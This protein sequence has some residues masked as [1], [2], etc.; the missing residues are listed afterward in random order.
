MRQANS[1]LA[2]L[3]RANQLS[4]EQLC[5]LAQDN[6]HGLSFSALVQ[7]ERGER[8]PRLELAIWLAR[9]FDLTV[10]ELFR[11]GKRGRQAENNRGADRASRA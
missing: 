10:E 6:G 11:N 2:K 3:R 4:R 1:K 7:Y 9:H 8:Q 5:A